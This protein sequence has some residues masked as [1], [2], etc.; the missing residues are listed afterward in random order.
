MESQRQQLIGRFWLGRDPSRFCDGVLDLA[1]DYPTLSLVG[2][3]HEWTY[4]L[5]DE[6][7]FGR[8]ASHRPE[9][10]TLLNVYGG[11][12]QQN[13][14]P[15]ETKA[16]ATLAVFG[17]HFQSLDDLTGLGIEFRL[18][19]VAKWLHETCF[20]HDF[21]RETHVATIKYR[22]YAETEYPIS[23]EFRLV[24]AYTGSMLVGGWGSEQLEISRPLR[25]QLVSQQERPFEQLRMIAW[26]F[27]WLFSWLMNCPLRMS[28]IHLLRSEP[29]KQGW[30]QRITVIEGRSKNRG[31]QS[32]FDWDDCLLRF[33]DNSDLFPQ[34]VAGWNKL[35][36]ER[37]DSLESYFSSFMDEAI[38]PENEFLAVVA[39]CEELHA[40]RKGTKQSLAN[41][42]G[43]LCESWDDVITK[44][45]SDVLINKIIGTR[46]Y[47]AH[48][49][50]RRSKEA[51]RDFL[52]LRYTHF[53][54]ALYSLELLRLLDVPRER[55]VRTVASRHAIRSRLSRE[56]FPG[57]ADDVDTR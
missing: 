49:T 24:L 11:V 45:V 30:S 50:A 7:F 42:L 15:V 57:V 51:A 28:D 34:L 8:L 14:V 32:E 36:L 54:R 48:R 5:C 3:H 16:T 46:H 10:V 56:Y 25:I 9:V 4:F 44:P 12:T 43:A 40:G 21:D 55:I 6:V 41:I 23:S 38:A 29:E 35:C 33:P 2:G 26:R 39:A 27:S 20:E 53:L 18:P 47:F 22:A 13:G 17:G 37:L 52:L 1:T 19:P 31:H